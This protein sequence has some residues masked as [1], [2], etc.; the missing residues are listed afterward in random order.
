MAAPFRV[1]VPAVAELLPMVNLRVRSEVISIAPIDSG[2]VAILIPA[3][4]AL[5]ALLNWAMWVVVHWAAEVLGV[6][7]VFVYQGVSEPVSVHAAVMKKGWNPA[8]SIRT[9]PRNSP[10]DS[11]NAGTFAK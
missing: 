8:F 3:V 5:P 4:I 10:V 11:I 7:F 1:S 9:R 6:Q 2:A